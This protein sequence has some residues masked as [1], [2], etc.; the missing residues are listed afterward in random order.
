MKPGFFVDFGDGSGINDCIGHGTHV[1][2]S[3]GGTRFGVAKAVSIVPVNV[4]RCGENS[5]ATADFV[6]GINWVVANHQAGQPAVA[7]I[8]MGG[9]RSGVIDAAISS[10]IADGI[11]VVAAA[12]NDPTL[13]SCDQSPAG[14]G[15]AITVAASTATDARASFSSYGQ[16][17]DIFAPGVDIQSAWIGSDTTSARASGTSMAA[18]QVAGAAALVLERNPTYSPAKVWEALDAVA[19]TGVITDRAEGDPDKLLHVTTEPGPPLAPVGLKA[20]VAPAAGV[21]SGEVKLSW[22]APY[23][24]TAITDYIIEM[25]RPSSWT[26][27][28]DGAST[29]TT[30][31]VGGLTNG[32][33]Y[34]FRVR[35]KTFTE[36]PTTSEVWTSPVWT[37]NAPDWLIAITWPSAAPGSFEADLTWAS[38]AGGNGSAV[39]DYIIEWSADKTA[40]TRVDDG[41]SATATTYTVTGLAP[42][43]NYSFRV[44]AK[45]ALGIGAW[46]TRDASTPA[47]EPSAP[48]GLATAVA[49]AA[50]VGSGQVKLSWTAPSSNGSSI[51][52][53]VVER[54]VDGNT[55]TTVSDGVSAA[56][57]S[58]LSG[59]TNGTPYSF[60]VAAVNAVGTGTSS[61][62]VQAT[63]LWKSAAPSGLSAAVAPANGLGSGQVELNWSAPADTGGSPSTGYVIESS[64]DGVTWTPAGDAASTATTLAVDGLTNGTVYSFRIAARNVVGTGSWSESVQATPAW[65]PA[66]PGDVAAAV[67]PAAGVGS[68]QIQLTWTAPASNGA[69]ITDYLV[70]QSLDGATWTTVEDGLSTEA[71]LKVGGLTNGT[72]YSF[73][74]AAVN[75]LGRGPWSAPVDTM[76]RWIPTAPQTMAAA[77]APA[78][79]VG[80]GQVRLTWNTPLDDSGA[81]INDY[82]IQRSTD[83]IVWSTVADGVSTTTAFTVRGLVN[84]TPYQFRVGARNDAGQGAWTT[85]VQATPR[86]K[87]AAPSGLRGTVAPTGGVRSGQVKLTWNAPASTG[88]AAVTDYVI[89]RSTNRSA[90]TTLRDG[91]STT[92]SYLVTRLANGTQYRFRVAARNAVGQGPWTGA[93]RATPRRPA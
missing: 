15:P 60:R 86:W 18:P 83:G 58:L 51:T 24:P 13:T 43:T 29:A 77:V 88:G 36:G 65:T 5:A 9:P 69:A 73:R 35:A 1:A 11:T 40:W 45:N 66:G 34:A 2:G 68:G 27:I 81:A 85:V 47:T 80:S 41:V 37:P 71:T 52:D 91:V 56:T 70:E 3:V 87:P 28:A 72:P 84:G 12:G 74:I 64:T 53:Y 79:G 49:P 25:W 42:G 22:T 14:A 75:A 59:L 50:G 61:A 78:S 32:T 62:A 82:V 92:R 38:G 30:Y 26:T 63:P 8:S 33:S 7:N 4:D 17:N 31:T 67:A 90:W 10:M 39:T 57:G 54:S 20:E 23:A 55:W 44:A 89:Q 21:G 46:R 6:A 19:T 48:V 93:V 76:P 16:C